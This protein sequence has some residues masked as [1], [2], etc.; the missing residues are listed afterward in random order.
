VLAA[1][2]AHWRKIFRTRADI[3][4]DRAD[5]FFAGSTSAR[6]RL[7]HAFYDRDH[8]R[9]MA[10]LDAMEIGETLE[11]WLEHALP[12]WLDE[13]GAIGDSAG[14]DFLA[15]LPTAE[16]VCIVCPHQSIAGGLLIDRYPGE[17]VLYD[18]LYERA[19]SGV[20]CGGVIRIYK[21]TGEP[22]TPAESR[23]ARAGIR[24]D[25]LAGIAG[26]GTTIR[27]LRHGAEG[28][29]VHADFDDEDFERVVIVGVSAP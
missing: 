8:A 17:R 6:Q 4:K 27:G 10:S 19:L 23:S 11:P 2:T 1:F 18:D 22:F 26:A 21:A 7:A 12:Y 16:Y 15:E 5:C 3:A 20:S 29:S 14:D 9:Q 28:N 25:L 24:R 13:Y